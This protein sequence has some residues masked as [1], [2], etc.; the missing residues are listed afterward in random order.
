LPW[1]DHFAAARNESLQHATSDWAFWLDAD[2]RLD[3][4]RE[5]LRALFARLDGANVA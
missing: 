2:D 1:C 5:R 3:D 4:N